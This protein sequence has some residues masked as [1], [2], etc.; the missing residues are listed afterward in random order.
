MK[1][2]F[3]PILIVILA[4][5]AAAACIIIF[6]MR[7][8]IK[9]FEWDI[10]QNVTAQ[11]KDRLSNLTLLPGAA[12]CIDYYSVMGMRDP[13]YLITS[14]PYGS[15]NEL[16]A[17]LPEGCSTGIENALANGEYKQTEDVLNVLVKRY[18]IAEDDLPLIEEKDVPDQYSA[19]ALGAFRYYYILEYED[20]TYRFEMRV[21]E[22]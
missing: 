20:G 8:Y 21:D 18:E 7:S 11:E 14:Y 1:K 3:V 19:A 17:A 12:G 22:V 10:H 15:I 4:F 16:C 6:T 9:A 13:S 2:S 5:A